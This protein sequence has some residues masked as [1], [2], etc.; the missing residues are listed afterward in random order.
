VKMFRGVFIFRGIAATDVA[1]AQTKTQMHPAVPHLQ[2]LFAA[3]GLWLH[4]LNLI[5]VGTVFRHVGL[6]KNQKAA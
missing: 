3:L 6:L 1:A 4:A 5:Q 2:T